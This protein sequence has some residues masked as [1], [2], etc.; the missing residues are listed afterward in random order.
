MTSSV[1]L[2]AFLAIPTLL[3]FLALLR[4]SQMKEAVVNGPRRRFRR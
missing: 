4:M 1:M 3:S 2:A